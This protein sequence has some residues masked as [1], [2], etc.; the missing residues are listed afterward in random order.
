MGPQAEEWKQNWTEDGLK[1]TCAFANAG[2][3]TPILGKKDDGEVVGV[4][5]PKKLLKEI[6]KTCSMSSAS[7]HMSR[8]RGPSVY[9]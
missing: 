6:Q 3:G 8:P 9:S 7:R 4:R 5:N 2:G 1:T